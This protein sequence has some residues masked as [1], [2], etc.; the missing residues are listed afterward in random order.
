M[1]DKIVLIILIFIAFIVGYYLGIG[2]KSNIVSENFSCGSS[3]PGCP[4]TPILGVDGTHTENRFWAPPDD[5]S[6]DGS[7]ACLN[8]VIP[9]RSSST[10]HQCCKANDNLNNDFNCCTRTNEEGNCAFGF[11]DDSPGHAQNGN[12]FY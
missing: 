4:N 9:G 5:G 11:W 10:Q 3:P 7:T 2:N 8:G 1:S 12:K 6:L